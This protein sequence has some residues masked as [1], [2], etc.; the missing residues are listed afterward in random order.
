MTVEAGAKE[1]KSCIEQ[2]LKKKEGALI[3][4]NGTIELETLFFRLFGYTPNQ[5]YPNHI[6]RRIE[7]HAGV[8]PN[9]KS[10]LD[11]WV[12]QLVEA[13]RLSDVL[14]AG[15][16]EP[17][18]EAEERLLNKTNTL[19][20]RIPLRSLEP[21]YVPP[22]ER[23]T[24]LLAG[25]RVAVV[26]SFAKTIDE[27]IEKREEIWPTFTDSL[28]PSTVEWVPI[29]TGYAP[30]LAK[31]I[32][33]WPSDVTSWDVAVNHI[34][35]QVIASQ[36]SIVLIGCGGLGMLIGSE[37]KKHGII[38]IVLGGATQV[39]FGIKG[40]RWATHSVISH[41]WN[42]A[43]VY[44]KDTETPRGAAQIEGGCYWMKN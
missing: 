15:W 20:P 5:Q 41:F 28:L 23:W 34:V 10:S 22:E 14:V 27:Q 3:G 43:W 30:S 11:R 7:L 42:D 12:F 32:G 38:A 6:S 9:S 19:A 8:W 44:P 31:G 26:S 24:G 16:Y 18:K 17:L 40:Q 2:A 36:A 1:I 21:Y 35:K 33:E 39:L 13:I 37:C 29:Q 25:Q 4:R